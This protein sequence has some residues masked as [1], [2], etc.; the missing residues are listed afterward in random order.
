MGRILVIRG[1]AIGDFILTLPAIRLIRDNFPDAHLE[2]LGYKH[3]ISVADGRFYAQATRCIEYAPL[4]NFFVPNASLNPELV[5]YF[6]SFHQVISYLY[7]PDGFFEGNVARAGVRHFLKASPKVNGNSHAAEQLAAPLQALALYLE[8][9]AAVIF[10]NDEDTA[11]ASRFLDKSE[12]PL[13]ALHPG[14]GSPQKNW[15]IEN[16]LVL[17]SRLHDLGWEIVMVGGEADLQRMELLKQ[18]WN[19]PVRTASGLP[20]AY[21]GA[22][23]GRCAFFVGHDSGVSHLAAAAGAACLLLFG[24]T[25]PAVWAPANP[26]VRV[27]RAPDGVLEKLTVA[28]IVDAIS[29]ARQ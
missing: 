22:I 20:L 25:D 4:S 19:F 7:D 10:P 26:K 27:I 9:P 11:F 16:W 5:E 29:S 18:R 3:I 28:E 24:P 8:N 21:L 2:I 23:L 13:I 12:K 17:G 1:G 15:P 14:S 6:G